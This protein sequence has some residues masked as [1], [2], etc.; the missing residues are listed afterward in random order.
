MAGKRKRGSEEDDENTPSGDT[1]ETAASEP[2]EETPKKSKKTTKKKDAKETKKSNA[3]KASS[4]ASSSKAPA[5]KGAKPAV[6]KSESEAKR[7]ISEYMI[8]QNRYV[9]WAHKI[10]Q[11]VQTIQ[12]STNHWQL[13]RSNQEGYGNQVRW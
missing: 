1:Q 2:Q 9:Y 12:S 10:T 7:M 5:K 6:I 3:K 4:S 13:G 11:P 8:S